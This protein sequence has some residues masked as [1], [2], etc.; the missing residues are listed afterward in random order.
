MWS[1]LADA[2][3]S[4]QSVSRVVAQLYLP[5]QA[6]C[7]LTQLTIGPHCQPIV[8]TSQQ[9]PVPPAALVRDINSLGYIVAIVMRVAIVSKAAAVSRPVA[10]PSRAGSAVPSVQ[11]S[12]P[13][14]LSAV[15]DQASWPAS[16]VT[17]STPASIHLYCTALHPSYTSHLH[18]NTL[19]ES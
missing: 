15:T 4:G 6:N 9:S 7:M 2:A 5:S 12:P 11:T 17:Q 10:G 19:S 1:G 16:L 13:P 3:L 18:S 14:P 8:Q